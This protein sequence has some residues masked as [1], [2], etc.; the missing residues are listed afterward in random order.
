MQSDSQNRPRGSTK[1]KS[2]QSIPGTSAPSH[3]SPG[4]ATPFPQIG[5][6]PLA[7]TSLQSM[8]TTPS[9]EWKPES[10]Q[11]TSS[12][13]PSHTSPG[14]FSS[15]S[16]VGVHPLLSSMQMSEHLSPSGLL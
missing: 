7:S 1:P 5:P 3:S 15:P 16:H 12:S 8:H 9:G 10:W 2:V 11:L 13:A 6:H 14:S 4:S